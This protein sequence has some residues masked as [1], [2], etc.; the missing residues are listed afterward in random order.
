LNKEAQ[1]GKGFV[2]LGVPVPSI[3]SEGVVD[4]AKEPMPGRPVGPVGLE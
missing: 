2:K 3:P 4:V 1:K